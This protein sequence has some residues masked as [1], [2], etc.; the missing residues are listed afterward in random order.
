MG[1]SSALKIIKNEIK[2]RKLWP[3]QVHGVKNLKKQTTKCYKGKFPN[4]HT[5]PYMLLLKFQDYW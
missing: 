4:T 2:L 5:I 1:T 3:L